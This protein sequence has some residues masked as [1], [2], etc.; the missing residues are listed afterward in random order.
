M[1]SSFY[2]SRPTVHI[3]PLDRS[4]YGPLKKAAFTEQDN[5][6]SNH[7]GQTMGIYDLPA[8][9]REALPGVATHQNIVKGFAVAGVFPFNPNIFSDMDYAP[10]YVT[11]RPF[12]TPSTD[13]VTHPNVCSGLVEDTGTQTNVSADTSTGID[14]WELISKH[15]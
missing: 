13:N 9:L 4:V 15:L 7:P 12:E 14:G 2:H 6:M 8:V 5:W 3:Q 11:D 10:S 1:K